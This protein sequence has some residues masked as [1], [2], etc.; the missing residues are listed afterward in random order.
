M[1]E[2][3][4][5]ICRL[6]IIFKSTS[7]RKCVHYISF[8]RRQKMTRVTS[9]KL[10]GDATP[11][12]FLWSTRAR[13]RKTPTV[14]ESLPPHKRRKIDCRALGSSEVSEENAD[15]ASREEIQSEWC[16]QYTHQHC[17]CVS[18]LNAEKDVLEWNAKL[19]DKC[20]SLEEKV[21]TL[22]I[23]RLAVTQHSNVFFNHLNN[24][25]YYYMYYAPYGE[26]TANKLPNSH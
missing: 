18:V 15:E 19:S 14:R 11:T 7:T 4:A 16:W 3:I 22:N 26:N 2:W 25:Y 6:G 23:F 24:Y 5:K 13:S 1:Q 8:R 20:T 21:D 12:K 17:A 9:Q 10:K